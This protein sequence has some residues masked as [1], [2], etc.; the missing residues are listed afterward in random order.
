MQCREERRAALVQPRQDPRVAV[1]QPVGGRWWRQQPQVVGEVQRDASVAFAQRLDAEPG[2]LAGRDQRVEQRRGVTGDARRQHLALEHRGHQRRALQPLDRVEQR[3]E[4][5]PRPDQPVPGGEEPSQHMRLDRFHLLAQCRQRSPAHDPQHVGVAPLTSLP[6]GAELALDDPPALGQLPQGQLDHRDADAETGGGFSRG[7]RAVGARVAAHEIG[8]GL[9]RRFDQR[10]R[11]AGR[12]RRTDAV[13]VAGGILDGDEP[14]LAGDAHRQGAPPGDQ[15]VE[16]GGGDAG[17]AAGLDLGHRQIAEAQQQVV[18]GV[19]RARVVLLRQVLGV[20]LERGQCR[21]VDQRAQ[22]ALTDE[23]GQLRLIDRQGVGAPLGQRRIAV[24]QVVGDVAEEE[25]RGKR[26]RLG[27]VHGVDAHGAAAHLGQELDQRRQIEDVTQT[28]A[29]GLEDDRERP[30]AGG[31]GQEIGGAFAL[32]PERCP[33]ARPALGQEQRPAGG[34]AEARRE[35]R[36]RAELAHHQPLDVVGIGHEQCRVERR[37]AL[38]HADDEAVVAPH[39]LGVEAALVA[40]L[41][42]HRHGP[43]GVDAAAEGREHRQ[44]PV[45]DFVLRA[46]DENRAVVGHDA[47]GPLLIVEV[48]QQVGGGESDSAHGQR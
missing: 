46:L 5:G 25:R 1:A 7:E 2:D 33:R 42:R 3:V 21:R 15:L 23:L 13:A 32:L 31:D 11:Q 27:H 35:Q 14:R 29:V 16:R 19:G 4:S 47:G 9:G 6:A 45:A 12:Q 24:V 48:L 22:L 37:V 34:F 39:H 30:E 36:R 8:D 18:D 26:R 40:Q 38:G 10:R 17:H 44:P 41:R 20:A 28:L 43:R